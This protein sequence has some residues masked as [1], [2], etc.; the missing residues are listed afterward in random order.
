MQEFK[1]PST[2]NQHPIYIIYRSYYDCNMHKIT[3]NNVINGLDQR[4]YL[5]KIIVKCV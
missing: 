2:P 4:T 5:F 1:N 3:Q